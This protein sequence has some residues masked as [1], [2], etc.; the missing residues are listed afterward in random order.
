MGVGKR[1]R[2]DITWDEVK[3]HGGR[4]ALE[5]WIV[6]DNHVYDVTRWQDRHPGGRRLLGYHTGQDATVRDIA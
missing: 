1:D 4:Q 6:I 5:K 2:C 3:Q